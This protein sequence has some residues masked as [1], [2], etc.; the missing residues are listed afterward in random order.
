[1]KISLIT[2]TFNSGSTLSDTFQSV[3]NQTFKNLEYIVI[4]GQSTDNTLQI[5]K[6]AEEKFKGRMYWISEKDRGIYDAMN[7]GIQKVT[8]DIVGILNSDDFYI[9]NQ[10]LQDVINEFECTKCDAICG[11][12]YFVDI[13]NPDKIVRVWKGSPYARNAFKKGWHPAHPTFFIKKECYDKYGLFDL[14]FNVSADFELM[15]RMIEKYKIRIHYIDRFMV[16]M[17]IGGESTGSVRKIIQGN[18]NVIKAF[19]KNGIT[20]SLFYPFKRLFPKFIGIIKNKIK[21]K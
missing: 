2:A 16:K 10:V 9:D 11:N 4:D 20:V 6:E 1:M 19:R 14:S 18:I 5:I 17:R 21:L 13:H 7:K 8:G 3:L 15:L 12:L